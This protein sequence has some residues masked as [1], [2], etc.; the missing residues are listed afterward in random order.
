[1]CSYNPSSEAV[2][3]VKQIRYSVLGRHSGESAAAKATSDL[4]PVFSRMMGSAV[5]K[6]GLHR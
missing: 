1:M 3:T 5:A 4:Y 2:A 6:G